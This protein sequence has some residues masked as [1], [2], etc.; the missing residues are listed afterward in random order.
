MKKPVIEIYKARNKQFTWRLKA[1]NGKKI[2]CAGETFH[3]KKDVNDS[4]KTV[5][6]SLGG[7]WVSVKIVDLTLKK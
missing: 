7:N 3:N 6:H 2:A 1:K 5:C 4:I